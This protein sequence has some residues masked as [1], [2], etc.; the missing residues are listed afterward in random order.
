MFD[1]MISCKFVVP[2]DVLSEIDEIL[3]KNEINNISIFENTTYGFSEQLDENGFPIA[4]FFDVEIILNNSNEENFIK[5][6]VYDK[7]KTNIKSYEFKELKDEDWVNEYIKNLEP[8]V[9]EKFYFYN[10]A[11]QT[12]SDNLD[13][14]PI[15]LNSALAFGSGHHQTTKGCLLN[16]IYIEQHN[17]IPYNILDMG[18]GTGILGICAKKIWANSNLLGIDIDPEAVRITN[19]NYKSNNIDAVAI[20]DNE[21]N[22]KNYYDLIFCNILKQPL[23]DLCCEFKKVMNKGAYIITS[24]Y[25]KSQEEDIANCY[26]MNNFSIENIIRIDEWVSIIFKNK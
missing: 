23:I 6:L 17:I 18:C 10:D 20:V 5:K 9:C 12:V 21:P 13:I 14:I 24:G 4:N 3:S 11:I 15:K 2:C 19:D 16:M 25:I 7:F 1:F 26:K 8:V 22:S